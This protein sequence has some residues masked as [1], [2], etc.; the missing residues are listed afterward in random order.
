[1]VRGP[2]APPWTVSCPLGGPWIS[3][4]CIALSC[5]WGRRRP[6]GLLVPVGLAAGGGPCCRL[7]PARG[8]QGTPGRPGAS[9]CRWPLCPHCL[10]RPPGRLPIVRALLQA[11]G[12]RTRGGGVES[13]D[14][15]LQSPHS[16]GQAAPG[17]RLGFPMGKG[18]TFSR[19]AGSLGEP[20]HCWPRAGLLR[21][22]SKGHSPIQAEGNVCV[23]WKYSLTPNHGRSRPDGKMPATP[24]VRGCPVCAGRAAP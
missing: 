4:S 23:S 2:P 17:P 7:T 5:G 10:Q 12:R 11:C 6:W 16:L 8:Q 22:R 9:P 3:S 15:S 13:T 14:F 21:G 19:S 18:T 20:V 1:M 24:D